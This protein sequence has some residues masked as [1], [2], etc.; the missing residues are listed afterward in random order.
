[1]QGRNHRLL[2]ALN[3]RTSLSGSLS[4][5]AQ[6]LLKRG[7]GSMVTRSG[8]LDVN[9]EEEGED[10]RRGQG[11]GTHSSQRR[12]TSLY[13]LFVPSSRPLW[14][15]APSMPLLSCLE[16]F[17]RARSK[18][19]TRRLPIRPDRAEMVPGDRES[20]R[21]GEKVEDRK[22]FIKKE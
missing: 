11:H 20:R 10:L 19:P 22:E 3:N 6:K 21:D 9:G 15:W 18:K 16:P 8:E 7:E 2:F 5:S 1:L 13:R 4:Y 17:P 12:A 14:T